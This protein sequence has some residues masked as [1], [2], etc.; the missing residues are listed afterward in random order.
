MKKLV[1][2]RT[3][4]GVSVVIPAEKS[5]IEKVLGPLTEKEYEAHVRAR[6]IP[7]DAV[8][9]RD[10]DESDLPASREFRN[11]WEDSQP[12]TQID[13]SC[14]KAARIA[15]EHLRRKREPL[16]EAQDKLFMRAIEAGADTADIVAEKQRLRDITNPFR[17]LKVTGKFND[18]GIL[19]QIRDLKGVLDGE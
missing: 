3:D 1:Y 2:T 11:A 9:V 17:S 4:G 16:L 10:I 5:A 7:A 12:G 8:N 19:Q 13:V 18:E 14:E 15:V 6:S